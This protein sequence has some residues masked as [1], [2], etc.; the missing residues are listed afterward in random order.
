MDKD[1]VSELS[2]TGKS[3]RSKSSKSSSISV[4]RSAFAAMQ[5]QLQAS[6]E[7]LLANARAVQVREERSR[8]RR[9]ARKA[10]GTFVPAEGEKLSL[11]P[12]LTPGFSSAPLPAESFDMRKEMVTR[13]E[14]AVA[15]IMYREE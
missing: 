1:D 2:E 5:A 4:S 7:A 14:N 3:A 11:T 9:G 8:G 12:R 6:S 13:A 15:I 10:K